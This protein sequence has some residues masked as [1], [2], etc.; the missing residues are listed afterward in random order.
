MPVTPKTNQDKSWLC[1][2]FHVANSIKFQ[3]IILQGTT[4]KFK[5]KIIC[6]LSVNNVQ[7]NKSAIV[8]HMHM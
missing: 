7:E 1:L 5:K 4:V 6:M 3:C 8:F 2:Q